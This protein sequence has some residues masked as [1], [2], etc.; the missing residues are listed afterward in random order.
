MMKMTSRLMACPLCLDC[1]PAK[2]GDAHGGNQSRRDDPSRLRLLAWCRRAQCR[3]AALSR[4][5]TRGS[6]AHDG[7][8]GGQWRAVTA[9]T[10]SA[11]D[12]ALE[13][14]A[15]HAI[16]GATSGAAEEDRCI[17]DR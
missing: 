13:L 3:S 4:T 6:P 1:V 9:F 14:F 5:P 7:E 11:T 10:P 17:K 8:S 16:D 2:L 12:Y 15:D